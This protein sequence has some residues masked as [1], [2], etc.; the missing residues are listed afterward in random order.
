M[1]DFNVISTV[2]FTRF[3]LDAYFIDSLRIVPLINSH[4]VL[5]FESALF[6]TSY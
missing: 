6:R 4:N 2:S 1:F 5:G 3:R